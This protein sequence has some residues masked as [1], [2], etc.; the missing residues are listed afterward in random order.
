MISLKKYLD[1]EI[2][3]VPAEEVRAEEGSNELLH[4]SLESYRGALQSMGENG[5]R[6]CP[7]VGSDLQ[8]SMRKLAGSLVGELTPASLAETGNEAGKELQLWGDRAVE[9]L[10]AKTAE[11]KELLIVLART[12]ESVGER[13]HQYADHFNQFTARLRT[14]SNLEDLTQVRA[15]L[16]QQAAELKTYVDQ[17]EQDSHKL[18]ETLQ[19]EV[20]AYET[21]L[22]KVEELAL[23][24]ALTGLSNRRNVEE[25]IQMRMA[26]GTAFCLVMLDL[27]RLKQVNDKHGHIAGDSLLQQFAQ[28]LRS[29]LRSSDVVGRWGGDEFLLVLDG[30]AAGA[31][32]QIERL[33]RWVFGEYTIRPGK[34]SGEVKVTVD[35]A[36]GFA[37]W[38]TG[39]TMDALVERADAEMYRHKKKHR[40]HE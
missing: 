40:T 8:L 35:A 31:Q 38:Q 26:R 13:D 34:G 3:E 30:D 36:V 27:N 10:N 37:Q 14:I 20:T 22:K 12:A 23:R 29:S 11:I 39:E 33:Q 5:A 17:M 15:S 32:A 1:M 18:V 28:E 4:A 24:D 25:R 9:Y 21:K 7:P 6:A 2:S 16:V 19:T